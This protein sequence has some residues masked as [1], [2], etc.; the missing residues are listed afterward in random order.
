MS[1]PPL[2]YPMPASA[3]PPAVTA[4]PRPRPLAS[5]SDDEWDGR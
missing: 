1:M 2:T 4:Y 5:L 3:Y